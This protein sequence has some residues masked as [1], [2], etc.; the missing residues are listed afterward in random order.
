LDVTPTAADPGSV[1]AASIDL[2]DTKSTWRFSIGEVVLT[3]VRSADS[4]RSLM[5]VGG[6]SDILVS[7]IGTDTTMTLKLKNV[8]TTDVRLTGF[9]TPVGTAPPMWRFLDASGR[10]VPTIDIKPDATADVIVA[11]KFSGSHE[12]MVA[13]PLVHYRSANGPLQSEVLSSV[14]FYGT[15]VRGTT[16]YPSTLPPGA[17][18]KEFAP[19]E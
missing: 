10:V 9:E 16:S 8:T 14:V 5:Q 12:F 19:G 4:P 6:E 17:C 13:T 3:T 7:S 2:T 15:G 18:A 1:T 11:A